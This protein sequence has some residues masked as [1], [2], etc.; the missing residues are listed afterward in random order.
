MYM[1]M[2]TVYDHP[3]YHVCI[4]HAYMISHFFFSIC[5]SFETLRF[6]YLAMRV[7][8]CWYI[9]PWAK[10]SECC[11]S[12]TMYYEHCHLIISGDKPEIGECTL[13]WQIS[14]G[15]MERWA[16]GTRTGHTRDPP[17][18]REQDEDG[19]GC[20]STEVWQVFLMFVNSHIF[21]YS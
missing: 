9:Y 11:L 5:F 12:H 7:I 16:G 14:R 2:Y 19:I 17:Q 4:I 21:Q 20:Y 18:L 10:N 3:I 6:S 8:Y 15:T 13:L 1:Y